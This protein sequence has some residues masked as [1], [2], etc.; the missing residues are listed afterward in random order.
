[1]TALC[2]Q[3][4]SLAV[5][6][7]RD[8]SPGPAQKAHRGETERARM[9]EAQVDQLL[10]ERVQKGD[11]H[12]F[13]L[14]INKYQHRIVSLVSRYVSDPLVLAREQALACKTNR[15]GDHFH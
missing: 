15:A 12:A 9:S 4:A 10:V 7:T 6:K 5:L 14:L 8:N 11:K 13:D 1:M 2:K 3:Q